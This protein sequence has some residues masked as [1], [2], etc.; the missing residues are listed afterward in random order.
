MTSTEIIQQFQEGTM[1]MDPPQLTF[2]EV[3]AK[4][5]LQPFM[6]DIGERYGDREWEQRK[7]AK[8]HCYFK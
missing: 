8:I 1:S 6:V 2:K 7:I 3:L 5:V 4:P